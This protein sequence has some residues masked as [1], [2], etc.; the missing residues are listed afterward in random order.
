MVQQIQFQL[1]VLM[2]SCLN[3]CFRC[4]K[5]PYTDAEIKVYIF[6]NSYK[7]LC[8]YCS[9]LLLSVSVNYFIIQVVG[10][11]L[12]YSWSQTAFQSKAKQFHPDQNQ[13]N[14]GTMEDNRHSF[15]NIHL[16]FLLQLA[17]YDHCFAEAA[18]A[19]FKEVM[20]SYDAIKL[21]R[22]SSRV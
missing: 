21:E 7:L 12:N 22:K 13:D 11:E 1:P 10:C 8:Y 4:R 18:E 15:S 20:T 6:L 5:T 3:V 14:K 9:N 2:T 17:P 19:K 16:H